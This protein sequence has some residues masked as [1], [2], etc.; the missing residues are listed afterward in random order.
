MERNRMRWELMN[1]MR[2]DGKERSGMRWDEKERMR[3]NVKKRDNME[4]NGIRGKGEG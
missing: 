3:R 2:W 4:R 1:E